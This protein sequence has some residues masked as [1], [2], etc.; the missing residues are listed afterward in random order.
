MSETGIHERL[1]ELIDPLPLDVEARL[2]A[3]RAA[4]GGRPGNRL[5]VAILAL[6]L[7]G[8]AVAF[9]VWTFTARSPARPSALL[10]GG[11]GDLAFE[12]VPSCGFG[13][14]AEDR[15]PP[16]IVV[17]DADGSNARAI[18]RGTEPAWSPDGTRIAFKG[19]DGDLYVMRGDGTG[20]RRI[21]DCR[22]PDCHGMS[23]PAWS[24]DGQRLAFSGIM[25]RAG[26]MRSEI[27]LVGMDGSGLRRLT[28]CERP[29][30]AEHSSPAWSPDG[31]R[32]AFA[33]SNL[34]TSTPPQYATDILSVDLATGRLRTVYGCNEGGCPFEGGLDW[35]PD[36]TRIVFGLGSGLTVI[37]ADGSGSHTLT[38]IAYDYFPRWSPDGKLIVFTRYP[39]GVG[40]GIYTVDVNSGRITEVVAG[41]ERWSYLFPSWQRR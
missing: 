36:G 39:G 16:V 29:G 15:G 6:A 1:V 11:N 17:T 14:C 25:R 26:T 22:G 32:I 24:P 28:T 38:S 13:L 2:G 31:T 8:A 30:C 19:L 40:A 10:G 33:A 18:G 34:H 37:G 41:S 3:V 9:A 21:F 27:Y 5:A 12:R 4:R 35:S 20:V 7:A 23:D